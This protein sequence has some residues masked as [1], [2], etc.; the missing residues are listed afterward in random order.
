MYYG[1]VATLYT[2]VLQVQPNVMVIVEG[3]IAA[4][5]IFIQNIEKRIERAL[6]EKLLGLFLWKKYEGGESKE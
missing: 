5:R 1:F 2:F 4:K 6:F 3:N